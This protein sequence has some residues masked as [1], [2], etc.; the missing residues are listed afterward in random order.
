MRHPATYTDCLLPVM[1]DLLRGAH[2]ILDPFGG[3]GKIFALGALLPGAQ[4]DAVEIEPEWAA[5]DARMTLGNA[6]ALPWPAGTFDA[7]C[8][9]PTY[10]NRMADHFEDHQAEKAYRRNTYRHA[11]GRPLAAD[12][13][14]ALQWGPEYREFHRRAWAEA[15]RVLRPGGKFVLNIKDHI[16]GGERQRVTDWHALTLTDLGFSIFAWRDIATPG[17]RYGQNGAARVPFESV[18]AFKLAAA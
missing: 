2:R 13:S 12:N 7:I 3:T 5:L 18:I 11:L 15:R 1:A 14:G 10:G 8:T 16:R 6:L 17:Q 4:I 9:S